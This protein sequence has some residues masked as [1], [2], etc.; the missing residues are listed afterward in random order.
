MA[1]ASRFG[2]TNST[3]NPSRARRPGGERKTP[4]RAPSGLPVIHREHRNIRVF[5][6]DSNFHRMLVAKGGGKGAVAMRSPRCYGRRTRR[7]I[8]R[9]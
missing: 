5:K 7:L 3:H 9:T 2:G 8:Q 6:F 1:P 4:I